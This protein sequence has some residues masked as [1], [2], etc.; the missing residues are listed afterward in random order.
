MRL[1]HTETLQ[2]KTFHGTKF[3]PYAI[4]SHTWGDDE[5][6]FQHI[7]ASS[8]RQNN[9]E[10]R[11]WSKIS[12]A[13]WKARQNHPPFEYIWIDTCCIDKTSSAE[14]SEEINSM[15]QWYQSAG[16]CY[17]YLEDVKE[18]RQETALLEES[19]K[20]ARWFTR[21]WTLQELIA[22][23]S[24]VF[25]SADW[26]TIGTKNSLHNIISSITG[27]NVNVL[28]KPQLLLTMSIARRMSW[29][30]N[31][32]TT[33]TEDI[34]YCLMGIFN[35]NMPLLYGEGNKA[36]IRL[37][38]EIIK[39][40]EDQ[41]LFAWQYPRG[42]TETEDKDVLENEGILAHHP[43]AFK[44]SFDIVPH[45][46]YH[47]PYTITN[48]GLKIEMRI[49]HKLTSGEH[50][51]SS[52]GILSCHY[53]TNLGGQIGIPLNQAS[54]RYYRE[55]CSAL[56]FLQHEEA[57]LARLSTVHV[58]KSG[59]QPCHE[60]H[61]P[62]CYL[63]KYPS[64]VYFSDGIAAAA[65]ISPPING[66]DE[67]WKPG[68][69]DTQWN[70]V[71]KTV[72]LPAECDGYFGA[73]EFTN[74]RRSDSNW[75]LP[76]GFTVVVRLFPHNFGVVAMV[77]WSRHERMTFGFLR[78]TLEKHHDAA[79]FTEDNFPVGKGHL[80][81]AL[82]RT[83]IFDRETYVVDIDYYLPNRS[84]PADITVNRISDTDMSTNLSS[85]PKGSIWN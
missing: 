4:L 23:A 64:E 43:I 68:S 47:A 77:P 80:R 81:V 82:E 45:R 51:T 24:V 72:V 21:G 61:S 73:L 10:M 44:N 12:N 52:V 76:D 46:T 79:T 11:G 78:R 71:G 16:I 8:G 22:P 83:E 49:S 3:P 56:V 35:V 17:A 29:A 9:T 19:L 34:A 57:G 42:L 31:R 13:C 63:R 30:A 69:V 27:V 7:K 65:V 84:D 33:R 60:S 18:V 5:V 53:E 85:L 54:E 59:K 70:R 66:S 37:Q 55:K 39:D 38:E 74:L 14:L 41:S 6:L 20:K 28:L 40:S 25:F 1:L 50:N 67:F 36:F 58:H 32:K 2:L 26:E 75:G 62:Y 15:F 48:R